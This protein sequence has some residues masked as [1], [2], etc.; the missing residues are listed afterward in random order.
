[1]KRDAGF[2]LLEM[3][4]VVF[5]ISLLTSAALAPLQTQREARARRA[6][7]MALA[8]AIEALY[9][10]AVV[11]GRLPCPDAGVAERGR[12]HR[13]GER[14]CV[15]REGA[16]PYVDLGVNGHDAWGNR[17]RYRLTA[18]TTASGAGRSFAA[19]DDGFCRADDADLDL[20]ERG[21]I[22][23]RI[24]GD[25]P[26]TPGLQAKFDHVLADRVPAVV[27]SHGANGYGATTA[28]GV[29]LA[30]IP[31]RNRDE[32]ENAD[33]DAVFYARGYSARRAACA[34]DNN[35]VS[36]LCEFDDMVRW[37]SPNILS[38]RMISSGQLP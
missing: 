1:M 31:G 28:A 25:D 21:D 4:V 11:H 24:R 17:L 27:L 33:D 9:G 10:F 8:Q 15:A 16:L 30:P 35:E 26:Q 18:I 14:A 34:D 36:A 37:L 32:R 22:E 23:I 29:E 12:E 5:I 3:A 38:V 19:R 2:T 20:C 7:A 13:N 6:T